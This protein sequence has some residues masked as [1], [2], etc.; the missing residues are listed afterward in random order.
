MLN[1]LQFCS[2]FVFDIEPP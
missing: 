2:G 1:N